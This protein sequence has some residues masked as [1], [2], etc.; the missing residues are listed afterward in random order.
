MYEKE[1]RNYLLIKSDL[2]SEAMTIREIGDE[3]LELFNMLNCGN[4]AALE[5]NL[6]D[7]SDRLEN[8]FN[9][10]CALYAKLKKLNNKKK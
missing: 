4:V 6:S 8:S 3:Y 1:F 9:S 2:I 5:E 7:I 10:I